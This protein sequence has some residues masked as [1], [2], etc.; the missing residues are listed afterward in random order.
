MKSR[1]IYN[2]NVDVTDE[3]TIITLSTCS[4]TTGTRRLVVQA[5]KIKEDLEDNKKEN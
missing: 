2:F 4:G 1:S 5:V 3:D